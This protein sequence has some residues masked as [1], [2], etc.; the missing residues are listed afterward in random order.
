MVWEGLDLDLKTL[1]G[2]VMTVSGC[3]G[4]KTNLFFY[5]NAEMTVNESIIVLV[6]TA[7]P[8]VYIKF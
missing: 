2:K 1:F 5:R 8:V 3:H 6:F 4:G 7:H